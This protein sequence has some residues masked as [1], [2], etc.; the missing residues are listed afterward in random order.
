MHDSEGLSSISLSLIWSQAT[1]M[2][3][4][5]AAQRPCGGSVVEGCGKQRNFKG[6]GVVRG[7]QWVAVGC[8]VVGVIRIGVGLARGAGTRPRP[9]RARSTLGTCWVRAD[10]PVGT[11]GGKCVLPVVEGSSGC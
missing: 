11:G 9:V 2:L 8:G 1:Q 3:K 6:H 4:C 7:W 10:T 5:F